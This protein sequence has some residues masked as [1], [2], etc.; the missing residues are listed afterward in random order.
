MRYK[1]VITTLLR[2]PVP[3]SIFGGGTVAAYTTF[4]P[5]PKNY[6]KFQSMAIFFEIH[7]QPV[8]PLSLCQITAL[9]MVNVPS[10]S[11]P[12]LVVA[13]GDRVKVHRCGC[14]VS[15][16]TTL[17]HSV[18]QSVRSMDA[19]ENQVAVAVG[20]VGGHCKVSER[21]RGHCKINKGQLRSL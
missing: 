13:R 20:E 15:E 17:H 16:Q 10:T 4:D 11:T 19:S 6:H 5:C 9:R 8:S 2:H 14:P 1:T 18:H 21:S 7:N 12:C 3:L